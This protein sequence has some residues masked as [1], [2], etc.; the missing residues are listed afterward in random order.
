MTELL[1]PL[2]TE[3]MD[4]VID[5]ARRSYPDKSRTGVLASLEFQR[6]CMELGL[7][8]KKTEQFQVLIDDKT[9]GVCG[10]YKRG[11]R[12]PE[13]VIWGDWFLSILKKEIQR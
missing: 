11:D 3:D 7:D 12:C 1:K 8:N 5:L 9:V 6:K 4:R 13:D 10:L 2:Q